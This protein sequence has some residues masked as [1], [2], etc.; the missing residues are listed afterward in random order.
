MWC[1][2]VLN[3]ILLLATNSIETEG[4]IHKYIYIEIAKYIQVELNFSGEKS[5]TKYLLQC[6][7]AIRMKIP[8]K[9]KF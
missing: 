2:I 6:T 9:L 8:L 1:G 4:N 5:F 7:L 3:C